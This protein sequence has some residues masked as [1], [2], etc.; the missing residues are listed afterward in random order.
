M[1]DHM[2]VEP[3]ASASDTFELL[4][5]GEFKKTF[6]KLKILKTFQVDPCPK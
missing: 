5:Q 1:K 4:L 6:K 3:L 2:A